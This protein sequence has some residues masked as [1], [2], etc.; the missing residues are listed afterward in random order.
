M[1]EKIS[2]RTNAL[3][4]HRDGEQMR[5]LLTALLADIQAA[6]N[7]FLFGSAVYDAA[8]LADAAG[9]T[10]TIPVPGVVMGD[11]VVSVSSE[12]SVAGI[13]MT[14]FVSA[15]NVV[16]VR[17]QNES[18]G[19]LDL[20]STTFRAI[21]LPKDSAFASEGMLWGAATYDTASLADGAGA[22][23][24]VTV[25]GAALGDYALVSLGVSVQGLTVTAYVSAA[26]TVAVRIQNESGATVDLAS[27]TIRVRVMPEASFGAVAAVSSLPGHLKGTATYDAG[28][29]VDGAGAT[30]T[31][32]VTGAVLGD[33]AIFG[34]GVDLAGITTTAYVSAADTV[35]VRLQNETTGTLDL[36]TATLNCR[37]IPKAAFPVVVPMQTLA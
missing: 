20:A 8:S 6:R 27:T 34:H 36:A 33:F 18:G 29:L 31:V 25:R 26:D 11:L 22:T 24:T 4:N 17:L 35:S 1:T 5:F 10:L 21:V 14:G 19:T 3:A 15:N 28:S 23:T 7:N 2:T 9:V 32:T 37:V 30:T 16:S 13:T 12:V